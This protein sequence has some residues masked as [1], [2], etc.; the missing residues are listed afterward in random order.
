MSF[1][2]RKIVVSLVQ[3]RLL[4]IELNKGKND[5]LLRKCKPLGEYM[6][7]IERIRSNK[8]K[9]MDINR[10]VEEAVDSCIEDGILRDFLIAHKAE[11]MDMCITEFDEATFVKGIK[12]EGFEEGVDKI[13][14]LNAR[15]VSDNRMEE[16]KRS[17]TDKIF[18]KKLLDEYFPEEQEVKGE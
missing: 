4:E 12:E 2:D 15:L 8:S 11:V 16:L 1:L 6:A 7:L 3:M 5:V 18:Q 9:R 13:N 17:T 14:E 10:A